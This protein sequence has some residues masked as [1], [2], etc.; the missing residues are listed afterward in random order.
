MRNFG[1]PFGI[2]KEDKIIGG[3]VSIRQAMWLAIPLITVIAL[4]I[5]DRTYITKVA[6]ETVIDP[7]KIAIKLVITLVIGMITLFLAF[8][9]MDG[10]SADKYT[11]R[12]IKY[13]MRKKKVTYN[14]K[15]N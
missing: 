7:L 4:F 9:T 14:E 15:I 3:V 1:V 11:G 10:A 12:L 13:K 8:G 5:V 6:G 2:N